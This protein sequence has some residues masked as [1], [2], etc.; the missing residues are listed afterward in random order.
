MLYE[1]LTIYFPVDLG[2]ATISSLEKFSVLPCWH[3]DGE[4]PVEYP[5]AALKAQ[6]PVMWKEG[7]CEYQGQTA[8]RF[9]YFIKFVNKEGERI[10]KE[11]VRYDPGGRTPLDIMSY[12]FGRLED[13]GMIG[14]EPRHVEFVEIVHYVPENYV[15]EPLPT[16][17]MECP[18]HNIVDLKGDCDDL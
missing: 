14:Y 12:F 1:V 8:R 6:T 10:Y 5:S 9:V 16:Q 7:T 2:P 17:P 3:I 13:L 15:S 11:K 18:P 4:D